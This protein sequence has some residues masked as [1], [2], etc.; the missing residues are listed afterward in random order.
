VH[1]SHQII[2]EPNSNSHSEC[3]SLQEMNANGEGKSSLPSVL[4]DI[5]IPPGGPRDELAQII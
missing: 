2:M 4:R 1:N 5:S 3:T